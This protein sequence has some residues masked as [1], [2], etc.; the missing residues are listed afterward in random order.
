LLITVIVATGVNLNS[1]YVKKKDSVVF[2][3]AF[4]VLNVLVAAK[5]FKLLVV[6]EFSFILEDVVDLTL[7]VCVRL[8][9]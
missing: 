8:L 6:S 3:E 2:P 1:G 9:I 4:V 5:N 7:T